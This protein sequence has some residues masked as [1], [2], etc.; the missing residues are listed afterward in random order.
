MDY[1]HV[2]FNRERYPLHMPLAVAPPSDPVTERCILSGAGHQARAGSERKTHND[3]R[4]RYGADG[5]PDVLVHYVIDGEGWFKDTK[6]QYLIRPNQGF[7]CM[8]PSAT[9]YGLAHDKYM[10]WFWFNLSGKLA[11]QLAKEH[12][13]E[14]GHVFSVPAHSN[15]FSGLFECF[16]HQSAGRNV[17]PAELAAHAIRFFAE[18]RVAAQ[19][20]KQVPRFIEAR[21]WI[22]AHMDDVDLDVKR[23][24][25]AI[26]M[27]R[28]HFT[29]CFQEAFAESPHAYLARRR[30]QRAA[31]LLRFNDDTIAKI[32][33]LCGFRSTAWFCTAFKRHYGVTP[34]QYRST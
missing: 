23:M 26:G 25:E 1:T 12:I 8:K 4:H 22:D 19:S 21:R 20:E 15:A 24:A 16:E 31:D 5:E 17:T 11:V 6:Q 18:L 3:N 34:V 32:A 10:E 29:R 7:I 9:E 28:S 27:T 30:L 14:Q 2:L 33:Q 13:T